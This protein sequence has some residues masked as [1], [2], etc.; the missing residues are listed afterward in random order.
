MTRCIHIL[1]PNSN[2]VTKCWYFRFFHSRSIESYN[3]SE[4]SGTNLFE[5]G[6]GFTKWMKMNVKNICTSAHNINI[7]LSMFTGG[8]LFFLGIQNYEKNSCFPQRSQKGKFLNFFDF[9]LFENSSLLTNCSLLFV[10][11]ALSGTA[12]SRTKKKNILSFSLLHQSIII[13]GIKVN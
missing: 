9:V 4:E 8:L 10:L 1:F 3:I 2:F 13:E 11:E 6:Y 5:S 12:N 7:A